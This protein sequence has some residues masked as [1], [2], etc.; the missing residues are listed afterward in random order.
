MQG[1][2]QRLKPQHHTLV[3]LALLE[4]FPSVFFCFEVEEL[5]LLLPLFSLLLVL[6]DFK[7]ED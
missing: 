1:D 6:L 2:F 4:T 7:E 3:S 5:F